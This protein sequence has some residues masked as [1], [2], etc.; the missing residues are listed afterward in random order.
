MKPYYQDDAVTIYHGDCRE[1]LPT[2]AADVLVTDPPYGIAF[3]SGWTGAAIAGDGDTATRDAILATWVHRPALVFGAAGEAKLQGARTCLVWHRPGSGMGDL[4]MPWQPDYELIHVFGDGWLGTT[5]GRSV[6][7]FPWDVFRG[8]ALHPHQKP[9]PLMR[10]LLSACPPGTV[11]D[12]FMGSGST[13][14]AAK[15]CSRRAIGIEIEERYCEI[16]A[17]RMGQEVMDFGEAA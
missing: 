6:L 15:D 2:V 1:I 14:R 3:K 13:L 5:R 7:T 16:A 10:Y 4:A 11:I 8:S 12:P 9:L 17:R